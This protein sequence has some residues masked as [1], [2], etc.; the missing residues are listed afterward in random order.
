V[1]PFIEEIGD[2][3]AAALR[4]AGR[5]RNYAANEQIFAEGE[6]A[7]ALPVV[8]TGRVKMVHFLETG[9]EVIISIFGAGEMFALPPVVDGKVYPATAI[10]MDPTRLL[11]LPRREFFVLLERSSEFALAVIKWMSAMLRNKTATIQNLSDASPEHRIA[12]VLAKLAMDRDDGFPVRIKLRR[13]D[14]ANMAGLTTETTIRVIR[15]MAAKG[16]LKIDRGKIVI[17]TEARL[18]QLAPG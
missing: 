5:E 9:K 1:K 4:S 17:E 15:R 8:I 18:Q 10:A 3:L 16:L 7:A 13:E 14:I 6:D 12:T 2:D 11:L